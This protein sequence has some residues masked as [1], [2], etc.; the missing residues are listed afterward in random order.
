MIADSGAV[1]PS[2]PCVASMAGPPARMK[3]NE[4]RKVKKVTTVAAS[5]PPRNS[6]SGPSTCVSQP[7]TKPTKATTMISGPGVVSPSASPS[8]ICAP[9][10][11]W[12]CS[13]APW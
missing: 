13:T 12:Y 11:Q 5:A 7:P 6:E 2:L 1:K 9:E 8:I 4:G 10:S 3:M